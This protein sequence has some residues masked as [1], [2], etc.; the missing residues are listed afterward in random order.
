MVH[1]GRPAGSVQ[2]QKAAAQ[3]QPGPYGEHRVTCRKERPQG[4]ASHCL[5]RG[6]SMNAS[7]LWCERVFF[8]TGFTWRDIQDRYLGDVLILRYRL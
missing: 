8:D 6:D 4:K 5:L 1:A 2:P 3:S 7:R